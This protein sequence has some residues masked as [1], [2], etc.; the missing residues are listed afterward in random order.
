MP[1]VCCVYLVCVCM[2]HICGLC[3]VYVVC[4]WCILLCMV[5]MFSEYMVCVWYILVCVCVWYVFMV[6]YLVS[7]FVYMCMDCAYTH[8]FKN[9]HDSVKLRF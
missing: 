7:V 9:T 5:Y 3:A 8:K 1:V 2:W 6:I 4:L